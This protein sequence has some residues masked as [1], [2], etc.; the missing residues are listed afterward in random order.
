VASAGEVRLRIYDVAGRFVHTL[1]DG[2][3]AA[4]EHALSWDGRGPGGA[5][6]ASGIYFLRLE[7]P[8]YLEVR[9]IAVLR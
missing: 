7:A 4:G 5:R 2:P 9:Q 3:V 1:V 6:V 8:G